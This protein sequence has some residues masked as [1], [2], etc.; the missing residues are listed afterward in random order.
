MFVP[1]GLRE[2]RKSTRRGTIP[3]G[4]SFPSSAQSAILAR[5][6]RRDGGGS[7][8][9]RTPLFPA[10]GMPRLTPSMVVMAIEQTFPSANQQVQG[11]RGQLIS[12]ASDQAPSIGMIV[13][14]V[15]ALPR[16]LLPSDVEG[17]L[18]IVAALSAMR[19]A[20]VAWSGGG[21][22]GHQPQL[23]ELA[24]LG[25]RHPI[26]AIL[27]ALRRCPDEAAS[28]TV[29]GLDFIE[30]PRARASVRT[31]ASTAH[32][33]LGNGEY[34]AAT[35]LAGSVVEALLLWRLRPLATAELAAARR[36]VNEDR[37]DAKRSSLPTKGLEW[38]SLSDFIEV[39]EAAGAITATLASSLR[40]T[41]EYRNLIH[42]GR[43]LRSGED[44][45]QATA[46]YALGGMEGL[47][48]ALG[49]R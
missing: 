2:F 45:S 20:L 6:H 9:T 30:D 3:H 21:H 10:P 12:L 49:S 16:E 46:L 26:A 37:R 11:R 1:H 39:A 28:E 36:R 33:A 27:E 42:P 31:D 40:T 19:A 14:L 43:V 38:Y 34:K 32:R 15:E 18:Q 35:V 13:G 5:N 47:I 48:E 25:G 41:R 29:G 8:A 23:G 24:A 17:H 22:P 4:A 44:A 7:T